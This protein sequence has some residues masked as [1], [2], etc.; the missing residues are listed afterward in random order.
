MSRISLSRVEV[1]TCS[2]A[3][4]AIRFS[5]AS[6]SARRILRTAAMMIAARTA[7]AA[8]VAS[9][10]PARMKGSLVRE[11]IMEAPLYSDSDH[12]NKK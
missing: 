7:S 8:T 11:V 4:S 2:R 3:S 9:A 6:A 1:S 10:R 5:A 12:R